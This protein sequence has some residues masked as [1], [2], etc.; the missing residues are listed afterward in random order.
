MAD[1]GTLK[2]DSTQVNMIQTVSLKNGYLFEKFFLDNPEIVNHK[3]N[4]VTDL[5][6][7]SCCSTLY[8]IPGKSISECEKSFC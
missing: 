8:W 4:H 5:L 7:K 3:G 6:I 1:K 2:H